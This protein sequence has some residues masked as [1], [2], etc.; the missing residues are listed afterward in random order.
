MALTFGVAELSY[1]YL[2]IPDPA[3]RALSATWHRWRKPG[4]PLPVPGWPQRSPLRPDWSSQPAPRWPRSR[5]PT[6]RTTSAVAPR[7]DRI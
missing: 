6:L 4:W 7:W 3:R 5:R 1:R 2:E